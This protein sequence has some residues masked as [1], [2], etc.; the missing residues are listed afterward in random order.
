MGIL[1]LVE[2][3][4]DIGPRSISL[5]W[6]VKLLF[7]D[8]VRDLKG[9]K[10]A[11]K[12]LPEAW[13]LSPCLFGPN[14]SDLTKSWRKEARQATMIATVECSHLAS[15]CE[16]G[17]CHTDSHVNVTPHVKPGSIELMFTRAYQS[18]SEY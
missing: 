9:R 8:I 6:A 12:P 17:G 10:Q 1:R 5:S 13:R 14:L 16:V 11:R 2:V 7:P 4:E 3:W 15:I 18:N